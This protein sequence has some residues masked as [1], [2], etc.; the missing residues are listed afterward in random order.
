MSLLSVSESGNLSFQL[1]LCLSETLSFYDGERRENKKIVS[2]CRI[3]FSSVDSG[4]LERTLFVQQPIE[5][6]FL[7]HSSI[8]LSRT[9]DCQLL[10]TFFILTRCQPQV[11]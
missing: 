4:R 8:I 3:F 11:R 5:E 6:L 10:T 7:F 1:N 2:C 9:S